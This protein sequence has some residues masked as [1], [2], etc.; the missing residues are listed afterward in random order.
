MAL[1]T[2]VTPEPSVQPSAALWKGMRC[3][4]SLVGCPA[5]FESPCQL[6]RIHIALVVANKRAAPGQ[7]STA[8]ALPSPTPSPSPLDDVFYLGISMQGAVERN[9]QNRSN[10]LAAA[11]I[12]STSA[13]T[14]KTDGQLVNHTQPTKRISTSHR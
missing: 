9:A 11:V 10:Q 13:K 1:S 3:S 6:I 4:L 5:S 8:L 2:R 14:H 7:E 12:P